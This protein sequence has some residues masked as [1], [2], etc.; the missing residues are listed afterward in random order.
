MKYSFLIFSLYMLSNAYSL[1]IIDFVPSIL[2]PNN[3]KS[4]E[5]ARFS[6]SS[7]VYC[8]RVSNTT[9]DSVF[10]N[11]SNSVESLVFL[12]I[13]DSNPTDN[14]PITDNTS[15]QS[16]LSSWANQSALQDQ[17]L[18]NALSKDSPYGIPLKPNS[19]VNMN[20]NSNKV[21]FNIKY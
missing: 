5:S 21:Q 9:K 6:G 13:S 7:E 18:K 19:N 1:D 14:T 4:S 2:L 3:T 11:G 16:S 17:E 20:I 10:C 12:G 15:K 8:N